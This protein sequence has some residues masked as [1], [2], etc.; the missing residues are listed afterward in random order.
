M[1]KIDKK[2]KIKIETKNNFPPYLRKKKGSDYICMKALKTNH[3]SA[4][5]FGTEAGVF[6]D[7]GF[8]TIVCGPEV[9][10]KLI[11]QMSTLT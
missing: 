6:S 9:L 10:N 5:S 7:I 11:N 4:V 2:C 3:T 8:Q 1:K